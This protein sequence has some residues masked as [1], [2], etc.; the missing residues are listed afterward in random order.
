M[1]G[2][3][4]GDVVGAAFAEVGAVGVLSVQGVGGDY[5]VAEVDRVQQR[6]EGGD[7]VALV[8]DLALGE[9]GAGVV[10]RREQGD[11]SGGGGARAAQGLAVDRDRLQSRPGRGGTCGKERSDRPVQGVAARA[12]RGGVATCGGAERRLHRSAG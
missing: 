6:G 12:G 5:G 10:H 2:F 4:L 8:G 7:L 11:V 9:D 1:V 3:D